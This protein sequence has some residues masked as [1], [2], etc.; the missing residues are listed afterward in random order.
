MAVAREVKEGKKRA[1]KGT[2]GK[3]GDKKGAQDPSSPGIESQEKIY[4]GSSV[5]QRLR[6]ALLTVDG[7]RG[8]GKSLALGAFLHMH[9]VDI[10]VITKLMRARV[11]RQK[12]F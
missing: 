1:K 3:R 9:E 4:A 11:S 6:P 5:A 8:A 2:P 12:S 7:L 10:C